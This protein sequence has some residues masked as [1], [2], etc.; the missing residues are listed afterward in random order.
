MLFTNCT[1]LLAFC[2]TLKLFEFLYYHINTIINTALMLLSYRSCS[3]LLFHTVYGPSQVLYTDLENHFCTQT[4]ASEMW[5][6]ERI[7]NN[8]SRS[9][10]HVFLKQNKTQV[11]VED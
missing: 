1:D 10:N 8:Y 3:L 6:V 7:K 5:Q 9:S 4:Q 11:Q 2:L